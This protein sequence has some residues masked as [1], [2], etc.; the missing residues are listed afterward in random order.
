M[1]INI[2][3]KKTMTTTI[4][5]IMLLI[6]IIHSSMDS[7]AMSADVQRNS[8]FDGC[9]WCLALVVGVASIF[10]VHA[11]HQEVRRHAGDLH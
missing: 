8:I 1:T 5:T 4:I 7:M 3:L 6:I 2:I 9:H 11:N 10:V